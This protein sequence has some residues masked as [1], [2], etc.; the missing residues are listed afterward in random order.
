M[1]NKWFKGIGF[2]FLLSTFLLANAEAAGRHG[3][4]KPRGV[5]NFPGKGIWLNTTP[6]DQK[7]FKEKLTLVYFWDYASINCVREIGTLK[8]WHDLYHPYGLQQVWVHSPEFEFAK[9]RKNVEKAL[10]RFKVSFPVFL[11]NEFKLWEAYKVYSW[12]TKFLVDDQGRIVHTQ[13][14]EGQ[15]LSTEAKIRELLAQINPGGILP[16]PAGKEET[17]KFDFEQCGMMSAETYTGYR[18]AN[19]WGASI[20]NRQWVPPNQT[21]AF[22]DRGERVERG[23]F[24]EGL[25]ASREDYLEHVRKTESL[26][27]YL[28]LVYMAH[29]VYTMAD[30]PGAKRE[31]KIYVTRDETP[32]PQEY[33]GAD[34]KEDETGGTYFVIE[35]PRLYYLIANEDPQPHELKLWTKT[36]G[37]GIHSF[38]FSNRCLSDFEH[39]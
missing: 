18:K 35:E 29:E 6:L 20:A 19:W 32:V 23:F 16:D 15:H 24:V 8:Q 1:V 39:L 34:L 30:L 25:W 14:G 12:P 5:P 3:T 31:A 28:G 9:D 17:E 33:R 36:S 10:E 38:S 22:K 13:T 26:T 21:V 11:D 37:V 7:V 27:D 4:S 2:C